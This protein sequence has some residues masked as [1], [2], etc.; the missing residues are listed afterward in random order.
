MTRNARL[1][2]LA[3]LI[4]AGLLL[5]A[6]ALRAQD[7]AKPDAAKPEAAQPSTGAVLNAPGAA[8]HRDPEK[9]E[10]GK[11]VDANG[12]P[13]Y[14]V[15]ADG[16]LD[17][18]TFSG[19]RRYHA[20]CHTCHGPEGLGSSYAPSLVES[21][22]KL[23]YADFQMTIVNGRQNLSAG[24]NRVMPALG[25]NLNVMCYLDDLYVYLKARS[26]GALKPGRPEK[27]EAKPAEAAENEKI[28]FGSK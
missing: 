12:E 7:A 16:T 24:Q 2:G 27:R 10:D 8:A 3:A 23:S 19:F 6:G 14:K 5:P 21:L 1:P 26:D 9:N 28:C 22:K 17:W 20:E 4:A 15:A 18:F 13:T 11:Y 25:E